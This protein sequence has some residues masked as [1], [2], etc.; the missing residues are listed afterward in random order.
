MNRVLHLLILSVILVMGFSPCAI[1]QNSLRQSVCVVKADIDSTTASN[2]MSYSLWLSRNG[3]R[4]AS[5][6]ISNLA[7]GGFGSGLVIEK[8]GELYVLTNS[9]VIGIGE[10]VDLE[11][12]IGSETTKIRGLSVVYQDDKAD[13]ALLRLPDDS[14]VVPLVISEKAL[15]DGDEVW[16]AGFP[17]LSG[18]PSWQIG[19]GIVSNVCLK[20]PN[21]VSTYIQHTAQ[22]DRGSSGGPLLVKTNGG[23]EVV[24]MN[25]MK[26]FNRESVNLAIPVATIRQA[27]DKMSN[28]DN[29]ISPVQSHLLA[30]DTLDVN[31]YGRLYDRMPESVLSHQKELFEQGCYLEGMAVVVDYAAK[32]SLSKKYTKR[33]SSRIT[34]IGR[35]RDYIGLDRDLDFTHGPVIDASVW[36]FQ[37]G[38]SFEIGLGYEFGILNY[39]TTGFTLSVVSFRKPVEEDSGSSEW[40]WGGQVE[41]DDGYREPKFHVGPQFQVFFGGQ[42][43]IALRRVE[44]IPY[45][46]PD[47]GF[48]AAGES[49]ENFMFYGVKTGVKLCFP[50]DRK[51]MF[52]FGLGYSFQH[53]KVFGYGD[54]NGKQKFNANGLSLRVGVVF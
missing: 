43:P 51:A 28:D 46:T 45:L 1:A 41:I 39:M 42:V 15:N 8:D 11:F 3:E 37:D 4:D 20:I 31:D 16:T 19:Q 38:G 53:Y 35:N 5:R 7:K 9:H 52:M 44:L 27:L 49:V 48:G 32:N 21:S 29:Y 26:V 14:S 12:E 25:T 47:V 34:S 10:K 2:L 6:G 50:A 18:N 36:D 17:G 40:P 54:I 22:V 24:G 30:I 33:P 13:I 23:Y